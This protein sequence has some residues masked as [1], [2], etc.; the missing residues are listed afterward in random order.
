MKNEVKQGGGSWEKV[1]GW[2]LLK[3]TQLQ[4]CTAWARLQF[5]RAWLIYW[6]ERQPPAFRAR[7]PMS[8]IRSWGGSILPL[9]LA[10]SPCLWAFLMRDSLC[11]L[12]TCPM[13]FNEWVRGQTQFERGIAA[14][15]A[16]WRALKGYSHSFGGQGKERRKLFSFSKNEGQKEGKKEGGRVGRRGRKQWREGEGSKEGGEEAREKRKSRKT[17]TVQSS[18]NNPG[19]EMQPPDTP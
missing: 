8:L 19:A 4:A 17:G 7:R 12:V 1:V 18:E 5:S 9:Q 13:H 15:S 11:S 14:L 3:G 10:A 6:D 2:I 16:G